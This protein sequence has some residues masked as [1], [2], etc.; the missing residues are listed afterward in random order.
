[1]LENNHSNTSGAHM[2]IIARCGGFSLQ[3]LVL[4]RLRRFEHETVRGRRTYHVIMMTLECV[5][6]LGKHQEG[7]PIV[8]RDITT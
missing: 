2:M 7:N 1:M 3:S 5:R 4:T 6:L 8:C